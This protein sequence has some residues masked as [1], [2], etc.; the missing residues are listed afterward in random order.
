ML[1]VP[2]A[3]DSGDA[4]IELPGE[5]VAQHFRAG[6]AGLFV[7][8][9]L[10]MFNVLLLVAGLTAAAVVLPLRRRKRSRSA[11]AGL[12]KQWAANEFQFENALEAYEGLID[13]CV[14]RSR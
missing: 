11:N 9:S 1:R 8:W 12:R 10:R 2:N 5:S 7:A 13:E 6:L 4:A 3:P 14:R